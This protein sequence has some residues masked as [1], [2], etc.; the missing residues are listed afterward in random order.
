MKTLLTSIVLGTTLL[1][2]ATAYAAHPGSPHKGGERA[3]LHHMAQKLELTDEQKAAI[4]DIYRSYGEK[5]DRKATLQAPVK[6]DAEWD[7]T[8]VE[9]QERVAA[10][11]RQKAQKLEQRIIKQAEIEAKVYA[12][13]TPEQQ[14]Q[15]KTLKNTRKAD[16]RKFDGSQKHRDAKGERWNRE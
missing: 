6:W 5:R 9:Y 13:L 1:A 11:A 8:S 14:E 7:P 4:A 12:V 2:G 10:I 3:P 15:W 16:H